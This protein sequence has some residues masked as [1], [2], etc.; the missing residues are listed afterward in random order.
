MVT[1]FETGM[2]R[3]VIPFL[4]TRVLVLSH[5]PIIHRLSGRSGRKVII[6]TLAFALVFLVYPFSL[7]R[8]GE[9][10]SCSAHN[11]EFTG[12]NPVLATFFARV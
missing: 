2:G 4:F 6:F 10:V 12:S 3:G 11:R 1:A 7:T 9:A 5:P 8:G